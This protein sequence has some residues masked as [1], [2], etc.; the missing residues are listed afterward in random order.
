MFLRKNSHVRSEVSIEEPLNIDWD[1]NE[2]LLGDVLG[3][4][5]DEVSKDIRCV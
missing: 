1:G 4:G 2:L 5:I 3:T